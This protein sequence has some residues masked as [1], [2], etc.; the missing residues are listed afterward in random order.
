MSRVQGMHG[1]VRGLE[2]YRKDLPKKLHKALK[3]AAAYLGYES[4]L[5]VPVD[6]GH[7]KSTYFTRSWIVGAHCEAVVGYTAEY[8]V[9]VHEDLELRHG[10]D[11]NDWYWEEIQAGYRHMRGPAQQAKF[12]EQPLRTKQAEM[13]QIIIDVM[14]T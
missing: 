4:L 10:Q 2:K 3:S 5:I 11:Y 8:A 1:V 6:T 14:T 13:M 9:L 7:L 12:L